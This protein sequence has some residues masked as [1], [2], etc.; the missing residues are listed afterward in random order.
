MNHIQYKLRDELERAQ[1]GDRIDFISKRM[2]QHQT[3]F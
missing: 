2:N 1:V 3:T